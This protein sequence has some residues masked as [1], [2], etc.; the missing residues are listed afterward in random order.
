MTHYFRDATARAAAKVEK[1]FA[2]N[3]DL[4][5]LG[6]RSTQWIPV[7]AN[8]IGRPFTAIEKHLK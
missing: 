2:R 7:N 4:T 6:F 8:S 3:H 1:F 5:R